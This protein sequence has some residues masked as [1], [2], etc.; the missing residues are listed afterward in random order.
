MSTLETTAKKTGRKARAGH[1]SSGT[2]RSGNGNDNGRDGGGADRVPDRSASTTAAYALPV[3]ALDHRHILSA[4]RSFK[5]GDFSVRM[6]EDLTGVDGQIAETFNEL[7][8]MVKTIRDEANDV[9]TAVGKEGQA[10]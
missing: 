8:E 4:M 2:A 6:R 3:P 10:G 1:G 5:R 9:S 7:V